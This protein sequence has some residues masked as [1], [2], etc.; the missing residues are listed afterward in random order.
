M[1]KWTVE[2]T[3]KVEIELKLM[4]YCDK[5]TREDIQVIKTWVEEME[6]YGPEH[7]KNSPEWHDHPLQREWFG[8]RSSAFSSSGRIIYKVFEDKILIQIRK[9]TPDHNYEK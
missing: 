7:I 4:F 8:H 2:M 6:R 1:T 3:S 9:V 5:V